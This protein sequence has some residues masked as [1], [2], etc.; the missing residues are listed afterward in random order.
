MLCPSGAS[1][2]PSW[3][4]P[5][6]SGDGQCAEHGQNRAAGLSAL[7]EVSPD[8]AIMING[9][10]QTVDGLKIEAVPAYNIKGQRGNG[11][12]NTSKGTANG[13]VITFGDKRVY[14]A[15]ETEDVPEVKSQKQ[16][17]VAFLPVNSIVKEETSA[18][19]EPPSGR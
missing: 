12:P 19:E 16:I 6:G 4:G 5:L 1:R 14:V 3:T 13:Y 17:D 15:G 2:S 11:K 10:T 7:L 18:G 9:E 8:A